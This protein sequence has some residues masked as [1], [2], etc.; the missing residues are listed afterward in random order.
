MP[1]H[2][3]KAATYTL[4]EAIFSLENLGKHEAKQKHPTTHLELFSLNGDRGTLSGKLAIE[5]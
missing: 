5:Q 3:A 4:K 2:S 1:K